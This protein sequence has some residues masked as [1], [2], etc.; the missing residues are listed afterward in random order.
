MLL[1]TPGNWDWGKQDCWSRGT[2]VLQEE[3]P[4]HTRASG[5]KAAWAFKLR[6]ALER[7]SGVWALQCE[8]SKA[9]T[10][11]P[12]S[13]GVTTRIWKI[14]ALNLYFQTPMT[15]WSL[16]EK[17]RSVLWKEKPM[18]FGEEDLP[19]PRV[20]WRWAVAG[21]VRETQGNLVLLLYPVSIHGTCWVLVVSSG[22][23]TI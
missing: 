11:E 22:R 1:L 15:P 14:W 3:S 5:R 9:F 16:W 23:K 20:L 17:S 21:D 12:L 18:N 19:W 2:A 8:W 13:V 7:Q 4:E 10:F 6:L